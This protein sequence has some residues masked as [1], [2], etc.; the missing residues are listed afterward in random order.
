MCKFDYPLISSCHDVLLSSWKNPVLDQK[1]HPNHKEKAP[2]I[3][4]NRFR[5]VWSDEGVEAYQQLIV[6]QLRRLQELWLQSPSKTALS[7]LMNATNDV[8]TE[9]A[10]VT[11][12][13]CPLKQTGQS[14][15][16]RFPPKVKRSSQLLLKLY[17]R[18]KSLK[19]VYEADSFVVSQAYRHYSVQRTKH[20]KLIRFYQ[21]R[22]A[23]A[24]DST[25]MTNPAST[26]AKIRA[27]KR[28][29]AGKLQRLNV[30]QHSFSGDDVPDGFFFA[31]NEMKC[32]NAANLE[33][34]D[35]FQDFLI[36]YNNI[37]EL[38]HRSKPV[39][40][41]SEAES[42]Q[43]LQKMK[44]NVND[45]CSV[46]PNHYLLAG[47]AG[48]NHFH[49][50]INAFLQDVS[51][52][53]IQEINATYACI[54][55]KGHN[56]DRPSSRSYRTISTCPVIAKGLDIYIRK[57]HERSWNADLPSTQFQGTGSSHELAAILLTE[58]I[59]YSKHTLQLPTY[60]LYLDAKSA[61]DNVLKELLIKNLYNVQ[62][63]D[64]SF[65]IINNRL[66]NRKTYVD[67]NG[68]LMSPIHDELGLEQGGTN[69]SEYYKIFGKEQLEL[70]QQSNLGVHLGKNL[71][72]SGIGQAD[73]TVL[74][75]N[76]LHNLFCLLKL[77]ILFCTKY[78]VELCAEKTRLQLFN[79]KTMQVD[80]HS[81]V[82]PI[83]INDKA[84]DFSKTAEH[85][86]ILRST[87]GNGPTILARI[88][89]HKKALAAILHV[90]MSQ[91]HRGNPS[92]SLKVLSLY[93]TPVLLSGLAPLILTKSEV[94][95][96]E[97]H[98]KE[99]LLR[100]LRL[101]KKTPR[102][103]VYFLAG[104]LPGIALLHSRQLSLFGM[105]TRDSG[106]VLHQH[107]ENIFLSSTISK[108]SWFDQIRDLCLLYS[109][110]H[111]I[112]LL[113][114]PLTKLNFKHLV[115]KKIISY[116][117]IVLRTEAASLS[118]LTYFHPEFMSLDRPHHLWLTAGPSPAKI[119]MASVQANFLSGRYKTEALARH[120]SQNKSGL[121]LLS[122]TC[123]DSCLREDVPHI[124][125]ICPALLGV[126]VQL[127]NYTLQMTFK[128]DDTVRKE[129]L[130]LC[131]PSHSDFC[132]FLIDCST[133]PSVISLA[134]SYGSQLLSAMF[135]ITRT[136][137]FTLHRE[138]LRR[139]NRWKSSSQL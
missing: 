56:K 138:R 105:I 101:P 110:P 33:S 1:I 122:P 89:S 50:L 18:L 3:P 58:C 126:R 54:L 85:V 44:P 94:T 14:K 31:I 139:L 69:S 112:D 118:S 64:Q 92:S 127:M 23:V 62:E 78:N 109:L 71:V 113:Q 116:W 22:D 121:C 6:P 129:I 55:F 5:T 107:A 37:I 114:S 86:G 80:L 72:I 53:S 21:A 84:I 29:S 24:R 35:H 83:R 70:A 42:L 51:T 117:E 131:T 103:V 59:S 87:E 124:L 128:F 45:F 19:E 66:H 32:R 11:N 16:R 90:G 57:I 96:I 97:R 63:P 26:F 7:I 115:K 93:C 98:Y 10:K 28:V 74:L 106:S 49:L 43:I 111:P 81:I 91:N 65:I 95:L 108:S 100:L 136:W 2:R 120:W 48:W 13:V 39:K 75:S 82:N 36:D 15:P 46:T 67:W 4:N 125:A 25:L 20:R 17:Q 79:S 88:A 119:C 61:F 47:P 123:H 73:D 38:S 27:S 102:S 30:G 52:T 34:S 137:V 9:C 76:D 41:I 130:T 133:I 60:V 135:E 77:T 40:P 132:H 68:V 12:R 99:T 104:S 8:L 134:D